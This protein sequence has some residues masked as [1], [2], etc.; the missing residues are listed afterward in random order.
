MIS[1]RPE[2]MQV[3]ISILES[4]ELQAGLKIKHK[5]TKAME[6]SGER[7]PP[8]DQLLTQQ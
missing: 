6:V 5:N 1:S 3:N 8:D 4:G 2:D 7:M